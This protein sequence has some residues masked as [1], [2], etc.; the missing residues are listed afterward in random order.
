MSALSFGYVMHSL[1]HC[2][3]FTTFS[4]LV[5]H[6]LHILRDSDF[7]KNPLDL[8]FFVPPVSAMDSKQRYMQRVGEKYGITRAE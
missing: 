6:S 1:A 3:F 8:T 4:S 2:Y 5:E 7:F